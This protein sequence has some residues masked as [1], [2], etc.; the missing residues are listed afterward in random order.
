[1]ANVRETY[2]MGHDD[3]RCWPVNR[4][5]PSCDGSAINGLAFDRLVARENGHC[6]SMGARIAAATDIRGCQNKKS[7]D[8][9]F[10]DLSAGFGD[11]GRQI[12]PMDDQELVP[13]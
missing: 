2:T 6:E 4:V 9:M 11:T 8:I 10:L 5:K 7:E 13:E 3:G 1:M 12:R